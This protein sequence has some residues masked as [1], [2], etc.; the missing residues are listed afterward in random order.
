MALEAVFAGAIAL[1][2][3]LSGFALANSVAIKRAA[4]NKAR[5]VAGGT[6]EKKYGYWMNGIE[7]RL[8]RLEEDERTVN[9]VLNE[10]GLL[11][12]RLVVPP[13]NVVRLADVP[14][15]QNAA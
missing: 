7:I 8:S 12:G 14:D 3:C 1:S 9:F 15:D 5:R 2:C 4:V 6:V 11:K 13:E 10:R